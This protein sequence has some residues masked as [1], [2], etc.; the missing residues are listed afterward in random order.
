MRNHRTTRSSPVVGAPASA[1][2]QRR[3]SSAFL[4]DVN[5]LS[6]C[7]EWI[8]LTF[9]HPL[10]NLPRTRI[11]ALHSHVSSKTGKYALRFDDHTNHKILVSDCGR[12]CVH[13]RTDAAHG[14]TVLSQT[15]RPFDDEG[16][17]RVWESCF[18]V[19][20]ETTIGD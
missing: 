1:F 7:E 15:V 10:R 2:F 20:S 19:V 13:K 17:A 11:I 16:G 14:Q 18:R 8:V 5:E 9:K 12:G 3:S 6:A 4:F